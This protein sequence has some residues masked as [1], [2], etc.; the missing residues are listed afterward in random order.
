MS[1]LSKDCVNEVAICTPCKNER[2]CENHVER[3]CTTHHQK[4][5]VLTHK[6]KYEE[7]TMYRMATI[8][9]HIPICLA[10]SDMNDQFNIETFVFVQSRAVAYVDL[11]CP[12]LL[13]VT[14][15][16]KLF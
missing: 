9:S 11:K 8:D 16:H 3:A 2:M 13:W 12:K 10:K 1:N 4:Y 6:I 5:S 15:W 7:H 14:L